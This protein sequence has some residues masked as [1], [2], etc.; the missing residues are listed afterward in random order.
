MLWLRHK[1]EQ[2]SLL[3]L[4]AA[5][6]PCALQRQAFERNRQGCLFYVEQRFQPAPN[7]RVDYFGARRIDAGL[8]ET[9]KDAC[10]TSLEQP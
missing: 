6:A 3:R 1:V 4:N 9:G 8:E 10:S 5:L 7:E 2:A